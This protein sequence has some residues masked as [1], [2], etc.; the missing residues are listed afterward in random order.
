MRV[1]G[2]IAAVILIP[3]FI[4]LM[5]WKSTYNG[6]QTALE[7]TIPVAERTIANCYQ[8][9]A[10]LFTNLEATV[11]RGMKQEKDV[12]V[13]NAQARAGTATPAPRLPDNATPEQIREFMAAQAGLGQRMTNLL[14]TVESMPN[15]ASMV[16]LAMF[17][18]QIKDTEQQCAILR[19]RYIETVGD[20]NASIKRVPAAWIASYHDIKKVD[21]LKFDDEVKIKASPR[22]FGAK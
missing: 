20:F 13:G 6:Y 17:Q 14:A 12:I 1:L 7:R 11:E 3:V 16:N 15:V 8:K 22:V 21:Q 4:F 10:D 19:K 9:R 2:I 5:Y 18:K